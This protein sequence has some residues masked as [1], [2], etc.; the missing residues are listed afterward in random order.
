MM[1]AFSIVSLAGGCGV[2]LF[3]FSKS[4]ELKSKFYGYP[5]F[6]IGFLYTGLQLALTV[7]IYIIGAFVAVP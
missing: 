6:R 7:L 1:F 3:A 4:E 5:V 2:T